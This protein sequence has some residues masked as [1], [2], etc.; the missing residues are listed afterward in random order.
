MGRQTGC[1]ESPIKA[2]PNRPTVANPADIT[3]YGVLEIE[4]GWD[5]TSLGAGAR[6]DDTVGA[7]EIRI[8][9]RC[10]TAV[11]NHKRVD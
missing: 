11:V 10:G 7:L 6:L 8:S 3:Q 9:V 5:R 4:Y 2:N 1:Y